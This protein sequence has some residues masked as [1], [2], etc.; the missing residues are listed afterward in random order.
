MNNNQ[1]MG[2]IMGAVIG[3]ALK[4]VIASKQQV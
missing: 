3:D 4:N 1:I 2:G